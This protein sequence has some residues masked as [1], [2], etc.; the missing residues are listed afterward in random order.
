MWLPGI[1]LSYE[2]AVRRPV[3]IW[4]VLCALVLGLTFLGG[5]L[6]VASY[7]VMAFLLYAVAR[8]IAYR[9]ETRPVTTIALA[10][11]PLLLAGA[12]AAGQIL[13]TL[14]LAAHSGRVSQGLAGA[15]HTAF[16]ATHLVLYFLPSFFG[17][18]ANP[19]TPYWGNFQDPGA[20]N[21]FETACYAGIL[22]LLLA[23]WGLRQWREMR[24]WY[25]AVL[26]VFA[27]L[28]ALGPLYPLLYYLAPGFKELAG[29]GRILCLAAFGIA[30]LAAVGMDELLARTEATKLGR[31]VAM[32][33]VVGV[34][35]I[36]VS[37][38]VFQAPIAELKGGASLTTQVLIFAALALA[39]TILISAR[40]RLR[41]A[42]QRFAAAALALVV[43]D[44]FGFGIGFNSFVEAKLAYPETESI[45]WLQQHV[46]HQRFTSLASD[47]LDWLPHN[48]PMI[49]GL[50]DMH[51]SDSLRIKQSFDL[52]SPPG[53][54]QAKYPD[55]D[56]PLLDLLGVRYLMTDRSLSGKWKLAYQG[57]VP[58]YEN[59]QVRPRAF[60]SQIHPAWPVEYAVDAPGRVV[61]QAHGPGTLVLMDPDFPGWRAWVDGALAREI[62][63]GV[64]GFRA[65]PV[66][67]GEHTVEFRYEPATYRVGLFVSLLALCLLLGAGAAL[68]LLSRDSASAM[69]GRS[70]AS[71]NDAPLAFSA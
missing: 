12:L 8:A 46:G 13:P 34:L 22:P 20:F 67:E 61:L 3:S 14:E 42:P 4:P 44:L 62:E 70:K 59:T 5:H 55:P 60:V 52:V 28:T 49:F 31:G 36:L 17:N 25:F 43:L 47:A 2:R 18:P 33:V 1:L 58:I 27:L 30:G 6:Q 21:F 19:N 9:K 29:L 39:S 53:V 45:R 24:A 32:L 15:L 54:N 66:S 68:F 56:S 7:L 65:V 50:R 37:F 10:L 41:L 11:I 69:A 40:A 38:A 63:Q 26:I 64:M 48:A 57:E 51:G 16:P 23:A 71:S 35:L